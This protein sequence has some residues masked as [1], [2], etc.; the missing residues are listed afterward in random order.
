MKYLKTYESLGRSIDEIAETNSHIEQLKDIILDLDD[1]GFSTNTRMIQVFNILINI[2]YE[3]PF[4]TEEYPKQFMNTFNHILSFV[5]S[6]NYKF[7][8]IRIEHGNNVLLSRVIRDRKNLLTSLNPGEESIILNS[9]LSEVG[10]CGL[11]NCD[12]FLSDRDNN[13]F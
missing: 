3:N 5:Q 6:E 11:F 8:T 7:I 13:N 12:I 4:N 2:Q 1:L 9:L 10:K